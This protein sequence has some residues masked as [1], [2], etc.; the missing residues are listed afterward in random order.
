MAVGMIVL[1]GIRVFVG[2]VVLVRTILE[3][4][5][6]EGVGLKFWVLTVILLAEPGELICGKQVG[7]TGQL[8]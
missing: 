8:D 3:V 6:T 4:D 1:V 5:L 7:Q 2:M